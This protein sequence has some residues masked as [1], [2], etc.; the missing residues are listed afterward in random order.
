[1]VIVQ[2]LDAHRIARNQQAMALRVPNRK[3]IHPAELLQTGLA[4]ASVGFENYFRVR[5]A[6][7]PPSLGLQ[8]LAHLAEVVDLAVVNDPIAGGRVLHGL[9]PEWGEI[10]N[11]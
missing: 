6:L 11:G 8:L 1:M 3:C 2:R 10:Q 4:P 7:E 5:V 9:M